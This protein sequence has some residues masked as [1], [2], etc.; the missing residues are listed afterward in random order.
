M[1]ARQASVTFTDAQL[2]ASCHHRLVLQL[3]RPQPQ[4]SPEGGAVCQTHYPGQTT[5]PPGHLEHS[6]SQEGQKDQPATACSTGY[7]PEGE[8]QVHQSWDRETKKQG[9]QTAKQPSLT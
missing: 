4:G 7:H 9:H 3:H 2:S 8:V 6:M 1:A 5:H